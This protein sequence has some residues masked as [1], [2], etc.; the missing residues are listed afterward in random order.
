[1]SAAGT[2][3]TTRQRA[4]GHVALV[5]V[6]ICFGLFPIFG[7]L[8]L[9]PNGF[10][11]LS[12]AAWRMLFGAA[13]L[14]LVAFA[15]HGRRAWPPMRDMGRLFFGSLLGVTL[16]MVLYLEGLARS[17]PTNAALIMS[18]IPVFTFALAALAG[19]ERFAPL[20]LLGILLALAG[21]SSRFWA[22]RPELARGH[23]LGNL[24]MVGNAACYSGFFVVTRPLLARLPPLVVIAWVFAWSVPFVPLFA[25]GETLFPATAGAPHWKALAFILIFPTLVAYVLNTIALARLSASTTAIYVYVQP[26]ITASASALILGEELTPA[27]L[28]AAVLV[29]AGIWLVARPQPR[30]LPRTA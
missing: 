12:L 27:M 17:T 13:A 18:L 24:L 1:M 29:F 25:H 11:P 30:A 8:A 9:R 16:N 5:A 6:Q 28:V 21:A 22:E 23:A 7:V 19:Q 3:L 14:L 10:T 15:V 26:L 2:E 20:R 4:E